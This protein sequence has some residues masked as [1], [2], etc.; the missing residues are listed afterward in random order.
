MS[1]EKHPYITNRWFKNINKPNLNDKWINN[2]SY[3]AYM[4]N[5]NT[6][7]LFLGTF[8][9]WQI[10]TGNVTPENFEFF[11]GSKHNDFWK[12][13]GTLFE[14]DVDN[15]D[16]RLNILNV[17]NLGITDIL[18]KIERNPI[19][20]NLD[21]DL[22]ILAY[23]NIV[24]LKKDYEKIE[25]I[26]ITSG[27]KGPIGKLN[28]TN[29]NVGTLLKDSLKGS[30]LHGFNQNGFVKRIKINDI[31]FNLITLY[32]PS[33]SAQIPISGILN[34]NNNFGI[35]NLDIST[36]RRLQWGYFLKEFHLGKN[37][38]NK[39]IENLWNQVK[40]NKEL[41]NFFDPNAQ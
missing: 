27:G 26:F 38:N 7:S 33:N 6:K 31:N 20:S 21:K 8:P 39:I 32:S 18:K 1:I 30:K 17:S 19:N 35:Q 10:S 23:N 12:C 28:L 9:I 41:L 13:L 34:S 25:N 29:K 3:F 15:L 11:Y 16:N 24:A 40:N 4:P 14:I 5:S 37:H 36:F 2:E 22:N